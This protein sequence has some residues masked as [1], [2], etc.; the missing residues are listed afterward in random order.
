M[1]IALATISHPDYAFILASNRDEYL[2][3]PTVLAHWHHANRVF[4]PYDLAREE[5]GT[6]IGVLRS[7]RVAVLVNYR[8]QTT[9]ADA[10]FGGAVLRGVMAN[11][12]LELLELPTDW[13]RHLTG[14]DK[15]GGFLFVFGQLAPTPEFYVMS[16][17]GLAPVQPLFGLE[18]T[19]GISNSLLHDPWPK[20]AIGKSAL[21]KCVAQL[22]RELWLESQLVDGLFGV[23][24]TDTYTLTDNDLTN[25]D[26]LRNSVF[27]PPLET[28]L[29]PQRTNCIGT[30]YGTR[31]HT[32]VLCDHHGNITYHER[33]L[34]VGDLPQPQPRDSAHTFAIEP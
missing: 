20:V 10:V 14:I 31:T 25:F 8:E 26:N 30:Y 34:Y 15:V 7:G 24:A 22:V 6:W 16:N 29:Y 5:H 27:I 18:P 19:I 11:S 32:L 12:F 1:C 33:D 21:D 13:A 28:H 2:L 4:L 9:Q 23:L 3:R 17:R